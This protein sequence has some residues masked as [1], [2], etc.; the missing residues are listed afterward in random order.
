LASSSGIILPTSYFP[1][2]SYFICLLTGVEIT[3]ETGETFP[4]QSLR[5]RFEIAGSNGKEIFVAPVHKP[6]GNH[7][8]THEVLIS[9]HGGWQ[10]RHWRALQT[11]YSSSPF[12][13]YYADQVR[14]M[15]M[16]SYPTL[17][18]MNRTI[19]DEILKMLKVDVT[20]TLSPDYLKD[21]HDLIDLRDAFTKKSAFSEKLK[22]YPQVFS[23]K[24]G[25]LANLSILDLLF[26][27]GPAA[28]EYLGESKG[29]MPAPD[30]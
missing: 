13:I 3:I 8:K 7:T 9:P 30:G 25:F 29:I 5:N 27:L 4:K 20:Y 23:Y 26:N 2:V 18:A 11:A 19:L 14:D 6:H 22:E 1:P 16:G 10:V 15:I 28:L 17:V 24:T 21:P 12:F